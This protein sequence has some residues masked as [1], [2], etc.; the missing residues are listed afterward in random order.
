[1]KREPKHAPPELTRRETLDLITQVR[2]Y[3]L[4]TPLFGGGVNPAEPDPVTVVR[5]TEVRGHLRFWWRATRAGQFHGDLVQMRAAEAALW[6]AAST[7][8]RPQPSQVQTL[9]EVLQRGTP[10]RKLDRNNQEL[11]LGH[12]RSEYSYVAFPLNDKQGAHVTSGV[13]FRLTLTFPAHAADDIA[14][15]VWAWETFGGLGARTRRGFGALQCTSIDGIAAPLPTAREAERWLQQGLQ[16]HVVPGTVPP[17][18][19]YL[20]QSTPFVTTRQMRSA[21]E[22][23]RWLFDQLKTF[24]QQR[25]LQE[26]VENGRRIRRPGRNRW[27]EQDEVRR[28]T[29]RRMRP[30]HENEVSRVRKFPRAVFGLPLII[31]YK[32]DDQ[33]DGDPRGNNT[34]TIAG[35][36]RFASPLIVRPLACAAGSIGVA[37][38]LEGS[39]VPERLS[40][41]TA[42]GDFDV[43]SD[44]SPAEAGQIMHKDDRTPLL[45]TMTDV[46][47]AF[48][49]FLREE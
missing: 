42:I 28:L 47:Q 46:L 16:Q 20:G 21:D 11:S 34:V 32:R 44:L 12:P 3:T 6:G 40:L 37:L 29:R 7:P 48:L 41:K 49:A 5:A 27:P 43:R 36:E 8:T 26:L 9:V 23:W 13:T 18:V 24:R 25:P 30:R 38:V 31:Q 17:W 4:I 39:R 10:L 14:A 15:A 33:R 35:K 45:G 22:S 2:E 1:M 19:P